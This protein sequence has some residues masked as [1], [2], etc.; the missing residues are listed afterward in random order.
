MTQ[1]PPSR[2]S[3]TLAGKFLRFAAVGVVGTAAHYLTLILIVEWAEASPLTGSSAGFIVGAFVNYVLNYRYTFHSTRR[4]SEALPRFYLVAAIGF[5]F[6]G[7][8]VWGVAKQLGF[9]YL[10]AQVAA[11]LIVLMWNFTSNLIWTFPEKYSAGR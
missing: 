3:P 4:H 5:I 8:I 9:H 11:T 7:A 10:L 6:N 2:W 1:V